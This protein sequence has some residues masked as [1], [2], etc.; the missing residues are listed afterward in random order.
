M[1]SQASFPGPL[2]PLP[3]T[4]P[5]NELALFQMSSLCRK[6]TSCTRFP[7]LPRLYFCLI[8]FL[9]SLPVRLLFTSKAKFRAQ[10]DSIQLSFC[11]ESLWNEYICS[12]A[13]SPGCHGCL[14][15]IT[16]SSF[17]ITSVF[18]TSG[19]VLHR[20]GFASQN[21]YGPAESALPERQLRLHP[22]LLNQNLNL[23]LNKIPG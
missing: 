2:P 10:L 6:M 1:L 15:V 3:H 20:W 13:Q 4:G 5:G 14:K 18:S 22:D 8:L 7:L 19:I 9:A 16:L 12:P 11:P 21:V 23:P 17:F